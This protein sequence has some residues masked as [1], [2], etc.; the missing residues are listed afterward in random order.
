VDVYFEIASNVVPISQT[1]GSGKNTYENKL[2]AF[3]RKSK[4]PKG[5]FRKRAFS[6]MPITSIRYFPNLALAFTY[7]CLITI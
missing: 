3:F 1:V 5:A 2:A 7:K 4:I 6:T